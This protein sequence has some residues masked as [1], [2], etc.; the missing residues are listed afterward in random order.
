[1]TLILPYHL[2]EEQMRHRKGHRHHPPLVSSPIRPPFPC[3]FPIY[4]PAPHLARN[5]QCHLS[6]LNLSSV[7]SLSF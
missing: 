5:P 2:T 7:S 4:L 3:Q 6:N 1:M